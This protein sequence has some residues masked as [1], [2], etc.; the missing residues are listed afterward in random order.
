M[1]GDGGMENKEEIVG[2]VANV[3]QGWSLSMISLF[4]TTKRVIVAKILGS[5][6]SIGSFL[7]GGA[8]GLVLA[9][10]YSREKTAGFKVLSPEIILSKDG[11]NYAIPYSEIIKIRIKWPGAFSEGHLMIEATGGEREFKLPTKDIGGI[12]KYDFSFVPKLPS[13]LANKLIFENLEESTYKETRKD[14]GKIELYCPG[15]GK[16]F[17]GE[18]EMLEHYSKAHERAENEE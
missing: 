2:C 9:D 14:D 12:N 7:A 1:L 18:S 3:Y 13:V 8:I 5:G 4:F 6:T 17:R 11:E 10:S 15:C 16:L